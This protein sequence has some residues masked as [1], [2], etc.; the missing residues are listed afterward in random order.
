[1]V[2]QRKELH[3]IDYVYKSGSADWIRKCK[4]E[5]YSGE[6]GSADSGLEIGETEIERAVHEMSF[7]CGSW[8]C[9]LD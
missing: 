5:G 6:R 8:K 2:K 7:A 1:M 9:R 4:I 3:E